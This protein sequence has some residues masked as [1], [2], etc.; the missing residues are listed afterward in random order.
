MTGEGRTPDLF[1]LPAGLLRIIRETLDEAGRPVPERYYVADGPSNA[2][3]IDTEQLVTGLGGLGPRQAQ[4]HPMIAALAWQATVYADLARYAPSLTDGE[5]DAPPADSISASAEAL[6]V[7]ATALIRAVQR[8]HS[9][10]RQVSNV[11][12][13]PVGPEGQIA[14][15][16][17]LF[18]TPVL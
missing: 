4:E 17:V 8:F 9:T 13:T 12:I 18:N 11:S 7:D 6:A 1:Q 5:G 2:V 15:W 14:R 16:V 3:A 10:M